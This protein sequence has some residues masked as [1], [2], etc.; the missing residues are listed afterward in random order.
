MTAT[1]STAPAART[2]SNYTTM[3]TTQHSST[4]TL[5]TTP[6]EEQNDRAHL[7]ITIRW[8]GAPWPAPGTRP[9]LLISVQGELILVGWSGC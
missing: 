8:A 2:L 9:A 1:T 3:S 6:V 5:T 4:V 7:G